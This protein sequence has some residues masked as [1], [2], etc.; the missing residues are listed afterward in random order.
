MNPAWYGDQELLP[1][2]WQLLGLKEIQVDIYSCKVIQPEAENRK[3]LAERVRREM[4]EAYRRHTGIEVR[5]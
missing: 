5:E 4:S 1:H 2:I 3:E